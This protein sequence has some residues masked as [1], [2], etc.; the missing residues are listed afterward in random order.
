MYRPFFAVILGLVMSGLFLPLS[1][2]ATPD[3]V[4]SNRAVNLIAKWIAAPA[5][6]RPDLATLEAA[7]TPLTKEDA[8]SVQKI[9]WQDHADQIRRDRTA[10]MQ[11][12]VIE[13][14][15]LK[16]KFDTLSF[17]D[18]DASPAG[19]RSLFLS[20]HGGGGAPAEV[21]ESQWRNQ[22]K[23]GNSYH[24]SEGIYLAP[25]APTDTWDLWHQPHID[26]FF[27][28]LI[29]N[30]IVLE[31]VNPDRVYILG[32]SAGGDGVYQLG[33]RMADRWAA[34]SMMAGHP[35]DASPLS[36]RNIG[37][38]IQVGAN[39]GAYH[40]NEIAGNWGR[41]MDELA[42][43]DPGS[44]PHFTELHAGKGHWMDLDDKKAIPWMEKF[45]RDPLPKKIVWEQNAVVHPCF[46][47]LAV[48]EK[49]ARG[50]QKITATR[51]GQTI[52]IESQDAGEITVL[53]NDRM[54]DLDS[55]VTITRNGATVFTG[56]PP[57]TMATLGSTLAMRGDPELIFSAEV[58]LPQ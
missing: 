39:D 11:A 26:R 13:L 56:V 14:D 20:L 50:G 18:K 41:R 49:Q 23:L 3:D 45:T 48:P 32:Y 22:I 16:M 24:P 19:G 47:W 21:N 54:M 7:H 55:P 1:A 8:A 31:G 42:A 38:S 34:A 2:A 25:R 36:L 6:S 35:N 33:P 10:E 17:G 27:D 44:Y 46:Y 15:G 53:L 51:E 29:Q 40:R 43:A 5:D 9:F 58:T 57:R 37:F 52:H 4:A 12:K 28:R 30:L